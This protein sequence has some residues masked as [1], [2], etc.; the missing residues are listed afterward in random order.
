MRAHDDK[1]V[2]TVCVS[3]EIEDRLCQDDQGGADID[4]AKTLKLSMCLFRSKK[5]CH[6]FDFYQ[7]VFVI[8]CQCPFFKAGSKRK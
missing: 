7:Q 6:L 5:M 8:Y 4:K 3:C 1:K 2:R